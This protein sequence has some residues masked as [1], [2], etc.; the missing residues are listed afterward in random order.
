MAGFKTATKIYAKGSFTKKDA[1]EG[2]KT[3]KKLGAVSCE[4]IEESDQWVLICKWE[5]F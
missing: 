2:A 5:V 3:Q 1:E 4:I